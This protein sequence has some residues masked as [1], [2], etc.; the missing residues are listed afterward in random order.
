MTPG[1]IAMPRSRDRRFRRWPFMAKHSLARHELALFPLMFA[2]LIRLP[3]N[4]QGSAG[5]WSAMA[6]YRRRVRALRA[7]AAGA[8][9]YPGLAAEFLLAQRAIADHAAP[10]G[11]RAPEDLPC[12]ARISAIACSATA[13]SLAP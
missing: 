2:R 9:D 13:R 1:A 8:D 6:Q 5:Y 3:D 7:D 11:C 12:Q 4:W 10:S